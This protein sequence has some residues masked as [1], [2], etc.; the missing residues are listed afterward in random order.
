MRILFIHVESFHYEV[1]ESTPVAM[2][3]GPSEREKTLG[4]SLLVL[5]AVEDVDEKDPIMVSELAALQIEEY[6]STI[7]KKQIVLFPF[8][9]LIGKDEKGSASTAGRMH[10]LLMDA[11]GKRDLPVVPFGWYK[12]FS[13][14]SKGHRYAVHSARVVP[15][16]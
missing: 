4:E 13:L 11:L 10:H 3:I 9:Y 6:L 14:T 7:G 2:D 16:G 12:K 15:E 1:K 5:Y 8:A